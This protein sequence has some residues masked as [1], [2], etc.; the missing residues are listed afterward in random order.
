MPEIR[1]VRFRENPSAQARYGLAAAELAGA[2]PEVVSA[3]QGFDSEQLTAILFAVAKD[4][5]DD[6]VQLGEQLQHMMSEK[7]ELE[8]KLHALEARLTEV[9]SKVD[10]L[11]AAARTRESRSSAR[12]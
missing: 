6:N 8:R 3:G 12:Q 7:A 11:D 4:L 10:V 5:R 1:V 2:F 9:S